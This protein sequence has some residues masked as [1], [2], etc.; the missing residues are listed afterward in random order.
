[1]SE[2]KRKHY[3]Y[4]NDNGLPEA[5]DIET[6]EIFAKEIEPKD[7]VHYRSQLVD[8]QRRWVP[9]SE[10]APNIRYN[11]LFADAF[12]EEILRGRGV[13]R[14]CEN[15]GITYREYVNMR[16]NFPEFGELID[17]A[18]KDR[19][20]LFFEKIEEVAEQTQARED[21]IALGK[22]RIDAYK[23]LSEVADPTKYGKKTQIKGQIGVATI[24]IETGIRRPGDEGYTPT[25][26]D[27]IES[28]QK[29]IEK[30]VLKEAITVVNP[31]KVPME[32]E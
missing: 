3:I 22:M 30:E 7:L 19:A 20:E 5:V 8:G 21:D 18:R 25:G 28:E 16:R 10:V 27:E 13:Q 24:N 12:V 14:A 31:N 9:L 23:H 2:E 1:M 32:K 17:E 4:I 15:L 26:M 6:G 29:R 11:P